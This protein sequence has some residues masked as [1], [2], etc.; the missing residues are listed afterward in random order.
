VGNKEGFLKFNDNYVSPADSMEDECFGGV[1]S[2]GTTYVHGKAQEKNWNAYLLFYE[3]VNGPPPPPAAAA[4]GN[5]SAG[6]SASATSTAVIIKEDDQDSLGVRKMRSL[7]ALEVVKGNED[8]WRRKLLYQAPVLEVTRQLLQDAGGASGAGNDDGGGGGSGAAAGGSLSDEARAKLA[9]W[10]VAVFVHAVLHCDEVLAHQGAAADA[11]AKDS[12]VAQWL[13]LFS[14]PPKGILDA[15]SGLA[16]L[17][18]VAHGEAI[19]K[20][21]PQAFSQSGASSQQQPTPLVPLK[22][23]DWPPLPLLSRHILQVSLSIFS[24]PL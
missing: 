11:S 18:S 23:N 15:P 3:R 1:R 2:N 14:P 10:G 5:S 17:Q 16:L 7:Q 13:R 22:P 24:A 9:Q 6:G 20:V 8:L 21:S 19:L 4:D 12:M